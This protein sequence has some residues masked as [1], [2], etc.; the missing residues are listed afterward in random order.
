MFNAIVF[1]FNIWWL[2]VFFSGPD[3]RLISSSLAFLFSINNVLGLE[4]FKIDVKESNKTSAAS[5]DPSKGPVFGL[6]DLTIAFND[7]SIPRESES[8]IG[9]AYNRHGRYEDQNEVY[10][11]GLLAETRVFTWDDFEVFN[12]DGESVS[13]H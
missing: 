10:G 1:S 12:Y 8:H 13:C 3:T 9:N 5:N 2:S 11:F 4:P 6:N 7:K